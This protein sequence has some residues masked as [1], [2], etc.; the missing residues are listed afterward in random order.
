MVSHQKKSVVEDTLNEELK[1]VCDWLSDNRLSLHSGKSEAIIFGSKIK[2]ARSPELI[3]KIKEVLITVKDT[4]NYLGCVLDKYLSGDLMAQKA[5]TKINQRIKFLARK[6]A[7]L[8]SPILHTLA[9]ALVQSHFDYAAICWYTGLSQKLKK[10]LQTAQNKLIRVIL[11]VHPRTHLDRAH[12]DKLKWLTVE[13]R[14]L[15]MKLMLT[16]KIVLNLVP[17][18]LKN[19]FTRVS[20]SHQH[21]TR[22]SAT[23]FIPNRFKTLIGKNSF[24]YST[25][26]EWNLLPTNLKQSSSIVT[27]KVALKRWLQNR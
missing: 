2:L 4:V 20:K 17:K 14:T 12:F 24:K 21:S 27:Y 18:Y 19:Y 16:F 1:N 11:K 3:I 15:Y 25:T 5:I 22:G 26:T 23:D 8:D 10:K 7:F 6:A 13:K 9:G